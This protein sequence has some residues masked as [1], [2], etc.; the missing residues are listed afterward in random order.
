VAGL[1]LSRHAWLTL[2][3]AVLPAGDAAVLPAV[4]TAGPTLLSPSALLRCCAATVSAA[5]VAWNANI[6]AVT[7]LLL[8]ARLLGLSL[9]EL[10]VGLL[11]DGSRC[12]AA[13]GPASS[14]PSKAAA[15]LVRWTTPTIGPAA[16]TP[17]QPVLLLRSCSSAQDLATRASRR[18]A[19]RARGGRL[20]VAGPVMTDRGQRDVS[21]N[22]AG[23]VAR[24]RAH[25][26]TSFTHRWL[27]SLAPAA[28]RTHVTLCDGTAPSSS[29][30]LSSL[31]QSRRPTRLPER[32]LEPVGCA[33]RRARRAAAAI[34]KQRRVELARGRG[35]GCWL[36]LAS[37]ACAAGAAQGER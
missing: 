19:D 11:V 23:G 27:S 5:T 6:L 35:D 4:D 17:F 14:T 12:C 30:R 29:H 26:P 10:V 9:V 13:S 33:A 31:A 15:S 37:S 36:A 24:D 21:T 8:F 2:V 20:G 25:P 28:T 1:A 18:R 16:R 34:R 3:P 22:H 32:G 7:R